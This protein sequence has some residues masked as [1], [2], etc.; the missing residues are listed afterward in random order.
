[1]EQTMDLPPFRPEIDRMNFEA[2]TLGAR[3][4]A[5]LLAS[6]ERDIRRQHIAHRAFPGRKFTPL[7]NLAQYQQN[8]ISPAKLSASTRYIS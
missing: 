5:R 6:V 8:A 1:M 7:L 4:G 3:T 2:G